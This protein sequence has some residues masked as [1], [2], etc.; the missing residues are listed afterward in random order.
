MKP[1]YE[2]WL[3]LRIKETDRR[4]AMSRTEIVQE[5]IEEIYEALYAGQLS[6]DNRAYQLD[7]LKQAYRLLLSYALEDNGCQDAADAVFTDSAQT[8]RDW[9][10][11]MV[12][13]SWM[14]R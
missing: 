8:S 13:G 3:Q 11:V 12:S 10:E 4:L 2:E 7:C 6:G 9:A 14:S 1:T 5:A